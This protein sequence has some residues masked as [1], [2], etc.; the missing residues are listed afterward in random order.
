MVIAL[1]DARAYTPLPQVLHLQPVYMMASVRI[2]RADQPD[3]LSIGW[4]VLP[5]GTDGFF[6]DS[7]ADAKIPRYC[8]A[9]SL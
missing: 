1:Y 7:A 9:L 3:I 4:Y 8:T 6:D 5:E 2:L